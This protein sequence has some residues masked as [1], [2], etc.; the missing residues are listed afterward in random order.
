LSSSPANTALLAIFNV[1]LLATYSKEFSM[2]KIAGPILVLVALALLLTPWLIGST[3][4]S[5]LAASLEANIP[6]EARGQWTIQQ[7]RFDKGWLTSSGQL[8]IG[9]APLGQEA[10]QFQLDLDIK[11]G[12]LLLTSNGIRFGTA[13]ADVEPVFEGQTL[14]QM[15]AEVSTT[16]PEV[17][18]SLLTGFSQSVE[19]ALN[20]APFAAIESGATVQ[21]SGITGLLTINGDES[22]EFVFDM[23]ELT[24]NSQAEG[25]Q[26]ELAGIDINSASTQFSDVFA[27]STTRMHVPNISSTAPI[28][29]SVQDILLDSRLAESTVGQ[30]K[31]DLY[32][33]MSVASVEADFPLQSLDWTFEINE[34]HPALM[35]GY[36]KIVTDIQSQQT[37][38]PDLGAVTAQLT[39]MSQELGLTL[40]QNSLVF[41]NLIETDAYNGNHK[42][43]LDI[44]W[45][46]LANVTDFAGLDVNQVINALNINLLLDL[47][48]KS[49]LKT[50]ASSFLQ[51]F[52]QQGML[53]L[54]NGRIKLDGS[55]QNGELVLN[56]ESYPVNE[57]LPF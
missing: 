38:A 11:H 35:D 55:L 12:P 8:D 16:P 7:T 46:G 6:P 47:D 40:I 9:Y 1:R 42:A 31:A 44:R 51:S 18:I 25:I 10:L 28:P 56:G 34:I 19:V 24:V 54:E 41:N 27:P 4:Q 57:F 2:K 13:F 48:E 33:R 15:L 43:D 32:Q 3:I 29:F 49:A 5:S 22:G 52:M 45:T 26:F 53:T 23:G 17:D 30:D 36:R 20:V 14:T 50:P 37:S 39:N 21:M